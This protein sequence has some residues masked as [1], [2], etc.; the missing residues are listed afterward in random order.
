MLRCPRDG[1]DLNAE[2][3]HAIQVDHCPKCKG[4]WYDFG[5]LAELE[6]SVAPGEDDRR[7]M[8]E[9]A[10]RDSELACP[11]CGKKMVAF[12][13]RGCDLELDACA[14]EHGFWLDPG[15]SDRVRE[16]M[17]DRISGLQRSRT[18]QVKWNREREAGFAPDSLIGRL[19]DLFRRR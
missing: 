12:D 9:Y 18:A 17:R 5:E 14:D 19:R 7:G 4:G 16:L 8:I 3:V 10:A 1:S 6:A 15:E 2:S 11:S 13:Y